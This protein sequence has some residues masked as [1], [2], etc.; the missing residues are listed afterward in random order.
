MKANMTVKQPL[1]KL[2]TKEICNNV[3]QRKDNIFSM[4]IN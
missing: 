3:K 4:F 1:S 2:D